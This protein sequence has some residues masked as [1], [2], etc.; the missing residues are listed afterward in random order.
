MLLYSYIPGKN[1]TTMRRIASGSAET[2][3]ARHQVLAEVAF[4]LGY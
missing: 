3:N 1:D 2:P 4:Q